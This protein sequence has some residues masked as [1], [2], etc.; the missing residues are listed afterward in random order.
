MRVKWYWNRI[1]LADYEPKKF[2]FLLYAL[3]LCTNDRKEYGKPDKFAPIKELSDE[4]V[5]N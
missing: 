5:E 3:R 1:L 4:F 2:Q